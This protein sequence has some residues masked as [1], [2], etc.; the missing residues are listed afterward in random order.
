MTESQQVLRLLRDEGTCTVNEVATLSGIPA[1]RVIAALG[2][3]MRA[4]DVRQDRL[5]DGIRYAPTD[6]GRS[7]V[8]RW[9]APAPRGA[10]RV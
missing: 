2:C 4:A 9:E 3:L 10:G 7:K 8:E 6:A 1:G 5:A